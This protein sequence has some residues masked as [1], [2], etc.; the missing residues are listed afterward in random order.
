[1]HNKP[2][3]NFNQQESVQHEHTIFQGTDFKQFYSSHNDTNSKDI[4]DNPHAISQP[5]YSCKQSPHEEAHDVQQ[6]HNAKSGFIQLSIFE[7]VQG[8]GATDHHPQS[9]NETADDLQSNACEGGEI[10]GQQ[11]GNNDHNI[12]HSDESFADIDAESLVRPRFAVH[13]S[14]R[15][16]YRAEADEDEQTPFEG[17]V[18]CARVAFDQEL[19]IALLLSTRRIAVFDHNPVHLIF[20]PLSTATI[21]QGRAL[22]KSRI[23]DC[24]FD[25][26]LDPPVLADNIHNGDALTDDHVGFVGGVIVDEKFGHQA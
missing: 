3:Y 8:L 7:Q 15:D 1:M 25:L 14:C 19:K 26:G 22:Q 4:I 23:I 20:P 5:V 13:R 21:D 24:T 9:T 2:S 10:V 6:P 16:S 18:E 11:G 12:E 17:L